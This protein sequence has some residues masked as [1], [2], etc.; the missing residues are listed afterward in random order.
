MKQIT[1]SIAGAGARGS[2][3]ARWIAAHPDRARLVA[4]ADPRAERARRLGAE[5]TV[6]DWRDL[7][8]FDVDAVLVCTQDRFHVEPALEFLG[9]GRSVLL[10]KPMA[11]TLAECRR[12][13]DAAVAAPGVFAV[14]HVLR[15]TPYTRAL[16]GLLAEG[17]VGEIQ[18]IQ[19]VEPVGWYHYAHSF[20]RGNWAREED[21]APMLLA[22]SCHDI[23]WLGAIVGRPITR[24]SSFGSLRYFTPQHRPAE[25]TERCLDCPLERSCAFSATRIYLDQVAAGNTGWPVSVIT[26]DATEAGVVTALRDGPY[27]RCVWA[28]D[29]DVVDRQVVALEFEGGATGTFQMVPFTDMGARR[30]QIFGSAGELSCDGRVIEVFDF[31]TQRRRRVE[32]EELGGHSGGDEAFIAAFVHAVATGDRSGI[33]TGP[34]ETLASHAAV[35]AIEAARRDGVVATL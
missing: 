19:H 31:A 13:H 30:T 33:L 15:Y 18:S 8:A 27:G 34:D 5:H 6:S 20:V 24:A 17:A 14:S 12:I 26:D 3:Y 7:A 25:A 32:V 35:F 10:E 29:N 16:Q 4:V 1:I 22:K 9:A 21:S 2:I 11:P 28:C 23:D